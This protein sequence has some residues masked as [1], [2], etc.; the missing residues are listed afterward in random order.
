MTLYQKAQNLLQTEYSYNFG[1]SGVCGS[2]VSGVSSSVFCRTAA[3]GF[4][5]WSNDCTG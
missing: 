2:Y 1:G 3:H 4:G 5:G